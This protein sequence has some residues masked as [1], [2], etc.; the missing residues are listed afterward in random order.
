[1]TENPN[2]RIKH[3][4]F[5]MDELGISIEFINNFTTVNRR[6]QHQYEQGRNKEGRLNLSNYLTI[7]LTI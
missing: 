7:Y 3:L 6:Q 5:S 4:N 2:V 1:M